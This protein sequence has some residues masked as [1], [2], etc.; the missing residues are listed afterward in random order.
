MRLQTHYAR[1][2]LFLLNST[3]QVRIIPAAVHKWDLLPLSGG[4]MI[5][6]PYSMLPQRA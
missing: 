1:A 6:L 2:I 5:F 3:G 4:P